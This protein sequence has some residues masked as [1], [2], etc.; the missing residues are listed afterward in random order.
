MANSELFAAAAA[1]AAFEGQRM[2][3]SAG[4][5]NE[6]VAQEAVLA[7]WEL[8]DEEARRC[9][10][11]R[12]ADHES[13]HEASV[14][15]MGKIWLLLRFQQFEGKLPCFGISTSDGR[16]SAETDACAGGPVAV[17]DNDDDLVQPS[18]RSRCNSANS[19]AT[20]SGLLLA[21]TVVVEDESAPLLPLSK[22]RRGESCE[23]EASS[24][25]T[26]ESHGTGG[27]GRG[28][29]TPASASTAPVIPALAPVAGDWLFPGQR[30]DGHGDQDRADQEEEERPDEEAGEDEDGGDTAMQK[31]HVFRA[32]RVVRLGGNHPDWL[33]EPGAVAQISLPVLPEDEVLRLPVRVATEGLLSSPQF[34]SVAYAA[35][36][37]RAQLPSGVRAGYYLGD[38]TGC[39]KGRV[40]AA[41]TWHLWN[42]GAR[43]HV[44]LSASND[45]L[46]DA[47]RDFKDL[48]TDLPLSGLSS[49][50][51]GPIT[52]GRGLDAQG[53]GVIFTSYSLLVSGKGSSSSGPPSP[54]DSRL[55]QIIDWLRRGRGGACGLI[56]LDEAHRAKNVASGGASR[57]WGKGQG[58]AG[59]K[60]GMCALELQRACPG[61]AVLYASATGAT[62]IRH[63]GYLERL[64]L[65]GRGRP[66]TSFEELRDAVEGGGLAAME[67][68]AM[69]MRAEGMLSCRSLSFTGASFRLLPVSLDG[70]T[71][72]VYV[73]A[74]DFWQAALRL[75]VRLL[76]SKKREVKAKRL[77]H[78]T[79]LKDASMQM[80]HFWSGQQRF[81]RQLLIC[82]KVD[83]A[84][85][86]ATSAQLRGESVV[87]AM[88]STGES[89]TEKMAERM[90]DRTAAVGGFASA[91]KEVALRILN[92]LIVPLMD[93]VSAEDKAAQQELK[94][95]RQSLDGM[96]LPPNPLDELIRQLGGPSKVAEMTGRSRRLVFTGPPSDQTAQFEERGEGANQEELKAFQMG[97]KHVAVITEAA[98]AGISLHCDIRLPKEAQRPRYMIAIE[99]PWEADKAIQQLGR[100][101]RSNQRVPPRF[102]FVVTDLGGEVRFVSAV[103]RR[104]RILG[105]MMR[106]DRNSAHGMVGSLAS[107]DLQ[108][109]YGRKALARFFE[110]LRSGG[111]PEVSFSFLGHSRKREADIN[112]PWGNSWTEFSKAANN[113]LD[114]V[115]LRPDTDDKFDESLGDSKGL[116]VFLNRLLMLEP[117]I[118]NAL[119]D[120]VAE[121]YAHLVGV[122]RAAGS[123]DEGPETLDRQR[124]Q[125][126]EVS[127]V[128][129]EVLFRDPETGAETAY[130]RLRLDR[131]LSYEAALRALER[132]GDRGNGAE[133]FYWCRAARAGAGS[134]A[135]RAV[136]LAVARPLQHGVRGSAD[137]DDDPE[138]D[139]HAP[140][141]FAEGLQGISG[142][143]APVTADRSRILAN[144]REVVSVETGA[145][146]RIKGKGAYKKWT[147]SAMLRVSLL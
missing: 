80:R 124:G 21:A 50:G 75:C 69:T 79:E 85:S 88:W 34:E 130:V 5:D 20:S 46:A 87:I 102:A 106:G 71:H 7:E 66:H 6:A 54:T 115:G 33:T 89:V 44:W 14:W 67:L 35:R 23:V 61:A 144:A 62:E 19:A 53:D 113:A 22:K 3:E 133:G 128:H 47:M 40:I 100:V 57:D 48:G 4:V 119:F 90:G 42:G 145:A 122:D 60:S 141:G 29:A 121:L 12:G 105:A 137:D 58:Q 74:C 95:L 117:G 70:K 49:W 142:H 15:H 51:Y 25:G 138:F 39:G 76:K 139:L 131:G 132:G 52:S 41:L 65:W 82:A 24:A 93:G 146:G 63:L 136:V 96:Q 59:S 126:T 125:R 13:S 8:L 114:L 1:F 127:L 116:N 108:N 81:F 120:A 110:L 45:L 97:K 68:L 56:A 16:T 32:S 101:H 9:W 28:T 99:L 107:F 26:G 84:V 111:E 77:K 86:L 118:Q 83:S 11:R 103:A 94:R 129:R 134:A 27:R 2:A 147:A 17:E 135:S 78:T 112:R 31:Q 18:K 123:F 98:S 140:H 64:G 91:P 73:A 37:F 92:D 10:V 143:C 55:G 38:G 30:H 104:L 109:R 72:A 36:R 43:R